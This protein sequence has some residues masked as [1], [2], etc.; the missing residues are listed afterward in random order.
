MV[1]AMKPAL[2]P[3]A[4]E[5]AN[6]ELKSL[7]YRAPVTERLV[8]PLTASGKNNAGIGPSY[9]VSDNDPPGSEHD[10]DDEL[11]AIPEE[12]TP[13]RSVLGVCHAL[14][15]GL[16]PPHANTFMITTL[17][18]HVIRFPSIRPPAMAFFLATISATPLSTDVAIVAA[19]CLRV[20][21]VMDDAHDFFPTG[22]ISP[23]KVSAVLPTWRHAPRA[24]QT[25]ARVPL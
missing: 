22:V 10:D 3:L 15:S 23:Q 6:A 7:P 8:L 2:R 13:A 11:K 4:R 16:H 9:E 5:V 14:V 24:K 17:S 21:F 20:L 12:N 25:M 1:S 19:P 18:H